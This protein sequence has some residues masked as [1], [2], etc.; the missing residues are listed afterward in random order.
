M[1]MFMILSN[2][3]VPAVILGNRLLRGSAEGTGVRC[4]YSRGRTTGFGS[5]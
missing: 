1:E 2:L 4:V 5:W 3:I